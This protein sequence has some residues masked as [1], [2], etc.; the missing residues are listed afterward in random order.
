VQAVFVRQWLTEKE[1]PT[2]NEDGRCLAGC[3]PVDIDCVCAG[4]GT[5][6]PACPDLSKDPDCPKDCGKNGVCSVAACPRPDP[7]CVIERSSCTHDDQC[8]QRKCVAD[9]AHPLYCTFFC[10]GDSDCPKDMQCNT[11]QSACVYKAL[12]PVQPGERCD[13]SQNICAQGTVCA[14]VNAEGSICQTSCRA[15]ADCATPQTC[16]AG[17]DGTKYCRN[18]L[19]SEPAAKAEGLA[20]KNALGCSTGAGLLWPWALA[21]V[22]LFLRRR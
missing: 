3:T 6:N 21:L 8:M 4:D 18:A 13:P 16:A 11:T 15:D 7:D 12:P 10:A 5:C 2:C 1:G 9:A 20:R 22:G 14:G 19:L 17:Y